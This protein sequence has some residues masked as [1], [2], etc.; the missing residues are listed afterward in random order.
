MEISARF[1]NS[2]L[3]AVNAK[4]QSFFLGQNQIIHVEDIPYLALGPFTYPFLHEREFLKKFAV[5]TGKAP[6]FSWKVFGKIVWSNANIEI[7]SLR[8]GTAGGYVPGC[9]GRRGQSGTVNLLNY[10][11]INEL[12]ACEKQYLLTKWLLNFLDNYMD[13]ILE[14]RLI[15]SKSC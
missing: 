11:F 5:G 12:S 4:R 3:E 9:C 15:K 7:S 14:N 2:Y 13:E 10:N 1:K 6:R 8:P